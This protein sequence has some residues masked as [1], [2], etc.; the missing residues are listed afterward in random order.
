MELLRELNV[1]LFRLI[2]DAHGAVL[3]GFFGLIS[4]LGDGLVIALLCSIIML[5]RLRLG[6]A[7]LVAFI[8]SGLAAQVL[9]R[10][11]DMPRPPAVLEHVHLLGTKLSAHSF[12]SGHATSDGV[13]VLAGF[14]LWRVRDWRA[15]TLALLFLLAAVGRV[16]GG[17]HFPFDVLAGLLLG[18]GCMA[19][20]WRLSAGWPVDAW[21]R[22]PWSWK[23]PGLLLAIEAGVLG[24][25]YRI[26]P[27]TAQPLSWMLAVAALLVLMQVWKRRFA[28]REA[29]D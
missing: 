7:A 23:L 25:G 6:M 28:G 24:L 3:D 27:S 16:Y 10:L 14:L 11:F 12:P 20:F 15:W 8:V 18:M 26:Q 1:A 9:K 21:M 2:N 19:A 17:V 22:S 4:G 29:G 13:M 5:F